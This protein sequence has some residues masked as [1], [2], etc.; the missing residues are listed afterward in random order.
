MDPK[1]L[2]ILRAMLGV[3]DKALPDSMS[4]ESFAKFIESQKGKL[5]GNPEDFKNLQKIISKKDYDFRK[6]KEALEKLKV[7]K[8]NNKKEGE[9]EVE[10]LTKE[11]KSKLDDVDSK[12]N[13]L[14]QANEISD[15]KTKYPDILPEFLVGKK[16]TEQ[17]AIVDK[18]RAMNKKLYG[19]SKHYT[20]PKYNDIEEVEKEISD[21]KADESLSGDKSAVKILQLGKVRDSFSD[22]TD[23][24]S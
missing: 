9:S 24:L 5:F 7:N 4:S 14:N 20:Q 13:K 12:L 8:N 15:L 21:I 2:K 17:T 11:L 10:K 6:T 23:S 19:D 22:S 16:E 3:D 1:V 18:Q